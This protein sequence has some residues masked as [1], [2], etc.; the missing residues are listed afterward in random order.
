MLDV[1]H[2]RWEMVNP[3]CAIS[4]ANADSSIRK[5][6]PVQEWLACSLYWR[7]YTGRIS[8]CRKDVHWKD[9]LVQEG[10]ACISLYRKDQ[11]VQ[12]G[13]ACI[14]LYRKDQLVL[15]GLAWQQGSAC[16]ERT[17]LYWKDQLV[18]EGLAWQEGSACTE[19]TSLYWKDQL[20]LEGLARTGRI[21]LCITL[22]WPS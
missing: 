10:S 11:L 12:E 5:D 16:T 14:S 18:L 2:G 9:Q 8:L 19:R 1:S 7:M 21:S 13:S 22:M 15:E 20:V 3:F 17:S 6:W 4:C